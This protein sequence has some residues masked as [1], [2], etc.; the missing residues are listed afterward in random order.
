MIFQEEVLLFRG[1]KERL[2]RNI[3]KMGG[4]FPSSGRFRMLWRSPYFK[5][6]LSFRMTGR[7]ERAGE[8]YRIAYR[9][10]PTAATLLWVSL[11]TLFLLTFAL[12]EMG[13]GNRD[14]A[15]AVALFSL[16]YPAVAIWQ[17]VSCH[18]T[19]QRFF[20]VATQ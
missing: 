4:R 8:G 1:S 11:L 6:G 18:R 15:M 9:F 13:N 3:T 14:S 10:L 16:L 19:M 5:W 2:K 7:Y 17:Y 20:A 12:W